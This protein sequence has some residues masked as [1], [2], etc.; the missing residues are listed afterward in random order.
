MF[1]KLV[2]TL[3]K[4]QQISTVVIMALIQV[5]ETPLPPNYTLIQAYLPHLD[6]ERRGDALHLRKQTNQDI[7]T[8]SLSHSTPPHT[9]IE[10]RTL[11]VRTIAPFQDIENILEEV[12][13]EQT[14]SV[15][16]ER[17][18][19]LMIACQM[20]LLSKSQKARYKN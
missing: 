11:A 9:F 5:L 4:E 2:L 16:K 19:L 12:N 17:D 13:M 18:Y 14:H 10:E 6:P 20:Q 8:D 1:A 7:D 3:D 15:C